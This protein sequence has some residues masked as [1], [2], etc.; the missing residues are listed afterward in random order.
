M[1]DMMIWMHNMRGAVNDEVILTAALL[2]AVAIPYL[3]PHMHDRYFY[4]ADVLSLVFAVAF[5]KLAFV[6]VLCQFASLLGYHAYLKGRYLFPMSYG[7]AALAV[8]IV[9]LIAFIIYHFPAQRR[10]KA[11]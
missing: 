8:V 11:R 4:G 5:P 10:R 6:P 9:V 3:L 1:F 7:A 2:F